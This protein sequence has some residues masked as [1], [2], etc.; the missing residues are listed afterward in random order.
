MGEGGY[1]A[2]ESVIETSTRGAG[3]GP[4]RRGD[5]RGIGAMIGDVSR[6]AGRSSDESSAM[7]GVAFGA[8]RRTAPKTSS[9]AD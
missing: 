2:S 1:S 4:C 9:L 7:I 3:G 5:S 8:G 6:S